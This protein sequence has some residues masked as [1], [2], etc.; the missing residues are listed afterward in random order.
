MHS[1]RIEGVIKRVTCL[2]PQEIIFDYELATDSNVVFSSKLISV[3]FQLKSMDIPIEKV[4]DF[5]ERIIGDKIE[6][7]LC[8]PLW[9]KT[10]DLDLKH[11]SL[12]HFINN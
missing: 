1:L 8:F 4:I 3:A 10:Y 5:M 7:Y 9:D 6:L 12:F 2:T 11:S